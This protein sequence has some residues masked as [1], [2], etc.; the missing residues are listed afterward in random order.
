[1]TNSR[2]PDSSPRLRFSLT[3]PRDAQFSFDS[4][5]KSASVRWHASNW[6]PSIPA[7]SKFNYVISVL[8]PNNS[9]VGSYS[10][11]TPEIT[12]DFVYRHFGQTLTFVIQAVGTIRINDH[13]YDFQSDPRRFR[14][15]VPAATSTPTNTPTNTPTSTNTPT[16][17]STNTPTATPTNTATPTSTSTPTATPTNTDTATAT[18]TAT[19]TPSP[20]PTRL[21]AS[22]TRLAFQISAPRFLR[23]S[24][25]AINDSGTISWV[26]SNWVPEIPADSSDFTYEVRV[27]YPHRT[28]GPY[29]VSEQRYS[30]S[31][32]DSMRYPRLTFT[33]TATGSFRLGQHEYHFKSEAAE[34]EWTKPGVTI[35]PDISEED[36]LFRIVS[37]GPVNIRSCPKTT[38]NPPLGMTSRG[39]VYDVIEQV[40][41]TD[42]E[43]YKIIFEDQVAYVAGWLRAIQPLLPTAT[44]TETATHTPSHTPTAMPSRTLAPSPTVKPTVRPT[45]QYVSKYDAWLDSGTS[46]DGRL[47]GYCDIKL[48]YSR[49][50]DFDLEVIYE[51]R[52]YEWYR[53]EITDPDGKRLAASSR[54]KYQ[55]YSNSQI[56]PG[57]YTVRTR[58]I[59]PSRQKTF[60]FLVDTPGRYSIRLGGSGC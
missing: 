55:S 46:W 56:E 8:A 39:S 52:T 29:I 13:S 43:W 35:T 11:T 9:R 58:E 38:C 42:G 18:N 5:R 27:I 26:K 21:P 40:A 41:G 53:V 3:S 57:L 23:V 47:P 15:Q 60:G 34:I 10:K 32:L 14:W 4:R 36:V 33:V 19:L 30:F 50:S 37:N 22:D 2:L 49:R 25:N 59:N 44:P 7:D 28:F 54:G 20:T 48:V 31:N 24:H 45:R 1:M 51:G 16:P 12:A 6:E 17:T